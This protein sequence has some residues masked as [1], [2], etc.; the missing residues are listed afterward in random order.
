[1]INEYTIIGW[2]ATF[3]QNGGSKSSSELVDHAL[4][5]MNPLK[6]S[7]ADRMRSSNDIRIS[8]SK[9]ES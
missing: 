4:K 7:L 3:I 1:M 2:G 5:T 9:Q 8:E 6:R